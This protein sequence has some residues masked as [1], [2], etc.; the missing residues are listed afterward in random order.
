MIIEGEVIGEVIRGL[1]QE[2]G[3]ETRQMY[4][5]QWLRKCRKERTSPAKG[6]RATRGQLLFTL[7]LS[8]AAAVDFL[9]PVVFLALVVNYNFVVFD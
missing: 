6:S 3:S 7:A 1:G 4:R 8:P 5:K 9:L 2:Y